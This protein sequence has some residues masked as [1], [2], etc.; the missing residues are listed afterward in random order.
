[1]DLML[2]GLWTLDSGVTLDSLNHYTKL[3]HYTKLNHC[4]VFARE[5]RWAA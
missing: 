1:M 3:C 5:S 4:T 2:F